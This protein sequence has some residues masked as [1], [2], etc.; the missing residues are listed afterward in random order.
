MCCVVFEYMPHVWITVYKYGVYNMYA[1]CVLYMLR[2]QVNEMYAC[3]WCVYS[4]YAMCIFIWYAYGTC[5]LCEYGCVW[6]CLLCI[7]VQDVY[8]CCAFGVCAPCVY[9]HDMY[10]VCVCV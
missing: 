10:V 9:G 6:A 7:E 2:V 4:V 8:V 3:V 1:M 5:L